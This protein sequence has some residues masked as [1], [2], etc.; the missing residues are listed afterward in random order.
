MASTPEFELADPSLIKPQE[1][2]SVLIRGGAKTDWSPSSI[3]QGDRF[4][5]A[6]WAVRVW[7]KRRPTGAVEFMAARENNPFF[8]AT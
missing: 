4:R 8:I 3:G 5:L 1:L 7:P 6:E 2:A